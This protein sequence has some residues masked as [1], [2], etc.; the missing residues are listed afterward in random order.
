MNEEIKKIIEQLEERLKSHNIIKEPISS[1]LDKAIKLSVAYEDLINENQQLK[2]QLQQQE[3]EYD[4]MFA[5]WHSRKLIKKFDDEFDEE[6]KK[7]NPNR[8]YACICPD[9]EEVYKRYYELKEQLQQKE[10]IINKAKD[11]IES[12]YDFMEEEYDFK[13]FDGYKLLEILDIDKGE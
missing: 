2:E 1:D 13:Y 11:L 10:D 5:L 3:E 7:K 9:A 6:D 8:D 12:Y 4:R